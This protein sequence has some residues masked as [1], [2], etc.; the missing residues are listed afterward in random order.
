MAIHISAA[1]ELPGGGT[2]IL[3]AAALWGTTGTAQSVILDTAGPFSIG[4]AR[5]VIGGLL[6]LV[7]ASFV[8]R[9]TSLRR[10]LAAS[11]PDRRRVRLLIALGAL[12]VA[13]YQITFFASVATTGVAVG[14]VVTIGSGPA[15]A[16]LLATALGKRPS[17]R[18]LL[19]TAGAVVGC[20]ALVSG[21]EA[22]GVVPVGIVLALVAGF[23]YASY[24]TIAGFLINNGDDD[25]AVI[26]SLFAEAGLLLLP[27]LIVTTPGWLL[28]PQGLTVALYL[29]AVTTTLGY[30]LYARGLRTTSVPT[31]TTLTMAEP[32]VAAL[33]GLIVLNERL[34]AV[35]LAGLGLIGISL[36]LLVPRRKARSAAPAER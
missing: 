8:E 36:L 18:W 29:G 14:T 31:A 1:R 23:G 27:G 9:G 35:A 16:G 22:A 13:V 34:S 6:L 21:G 20:A 24:A 26:A 3:L 15:F 28:S 4:A 7:L 12:S 11:R 2:S 32:V 19:A 33:L 10:L 17:S 5:I 30:V 25:L